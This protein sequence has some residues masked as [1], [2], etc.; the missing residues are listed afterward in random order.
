MGSQRLNWRCPGLRAA[1]GRAV[2]LRGGFAWRRRREG[3]FR[4]GSQQAKSRYRTQLQRLER[5]RPRRLKRPGKQVPG[6]RCRRRGAWLPTG[7][8]T[9]LGLGTR[10][11]GCATVPLSPIISGKRLS[12]AQFSQGGGGACRWLVTPGLWALVW[13]SQGPPRMEAPLQSC[14]RLPRVL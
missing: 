1:R 8:M 12:L 3:G 10:A 4:G 2:R 9:S 14:S 13:G 11:R 5:Q 6:G 7:A